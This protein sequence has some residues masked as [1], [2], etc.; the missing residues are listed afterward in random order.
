MPMNDDRPMADPTRIEMAQQ[1]FPILELSPEQYVARWSHTIMCSSFDQFRYPDPA[2]TAWIDEMHRLLNTAGESERC[3]R[4]HLSPD[5]YAA[6][7]ADIAAGEW[8]CA[9]K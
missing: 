4:A 2:L 7:Q 3:R 5:E 8:C 9:G 1:V 6:V